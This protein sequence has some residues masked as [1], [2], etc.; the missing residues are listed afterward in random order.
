MSTEH[1]RS[2]LSV[3][4]LSKASVTYAEEMRA[5]IAEKNALSS[6]DEYE[7]VIATARMLHLETLACARYEA[8]V[9]QIV[10]AYAEAAAAQNL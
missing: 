6:L 10:L 1:I 8:A 5:I 4:A 7:Q 3:K 9:A 2:S